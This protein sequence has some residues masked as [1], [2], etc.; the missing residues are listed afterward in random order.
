ME[1]LADDEYQCFN[2]NRI[3]R[4]RVFEVTGEWN[5][6]HFEDELPSVEVEGSVGLECYCSRRCLDARLRLVMAAEGVPIR[7]PGIG[8][9][10]KCAKC[11]GPVDMTRFHLTYLED[12]VEYATTLELD[13]LAVVCQHCEAVGELGAELLDTYDRSSCECPSDIALSVDRG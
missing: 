6:T 11:N 9:I 7:H 10:E 8:P 5:R 13:Y 2:C 4:G 12:C 1:S 3:F